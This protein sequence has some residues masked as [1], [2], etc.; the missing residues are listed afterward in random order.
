MADDLPELREGRA[1]DSD[2]KSP[3]H[4]TIGIETLQP[5][6][7]SQSDSTK[8]QGDRHREKRTEYDDEWLKM[9]GAFVCSSTSTITPW[10]TCD[11]SI[12]IPSRFI[13]HS[14]FRP[15]P[16]TLRSVASG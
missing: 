3:S 6:V 5:K 10:L 13:S 9:T 2:A 11:T 7:G 8:A 16:V 4:L 12:S 14:T 15:Q 1:F